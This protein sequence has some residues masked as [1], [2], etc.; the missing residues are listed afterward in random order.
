MD[1]AT[2]TFTVGVLPTQH[3]LP[4]CKLPACVDLQG[5]MAWHIR[6]FLC[7]CRLPIWPRSCKP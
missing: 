7:I 5:Q 6:A 3:L 1:M 2:L 4:C